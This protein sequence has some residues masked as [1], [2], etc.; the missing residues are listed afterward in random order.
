V[1]ADV[2]LA[3]GV[4]A[5]SVFLGDDLI[6]WLLLALGGAMFLGNVVALARP[7]V[8][9]RDE[10]DLEQAPRARSILMAAIGFVVAVAALGALIA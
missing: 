7:P 5:E 10:G 1:I 2:P 4:A 6:V 9:P 3:G 8:R